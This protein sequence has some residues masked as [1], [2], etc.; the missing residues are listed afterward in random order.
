M[1]ACYAHNELFEVSLGLLRDMKLSG[2]EVDV[3]TYS[4]IISLFVSEQSFQ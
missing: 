4:G 1:I 3:A 2:L